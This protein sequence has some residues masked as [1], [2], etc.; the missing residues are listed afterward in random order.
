MTRPS[1]PANG[2]KGHLLSLFDG[3]YCFRVYGDNYTF[4]DYNL[5]H[6]D[7]Q[8]TITDSDSAF[9]ENENGTLTLDHAPATLGITS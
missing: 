3:T 8:I 7:L 2:T 9:Y 6:S 1:K 5:Q 4:K